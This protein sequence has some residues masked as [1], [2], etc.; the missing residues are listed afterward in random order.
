MQPKS[1]VWLDK[2]R[3]IWS[4]ILPV[5]VRHFHTYHYTVS[6]DVMVCLL[7]YVFTWSWTLSEPVW[8]KTWLNVPRNSKRGRRNPIKALGPHPDHRDN[9]RAFN[10]SLVDIQ[11]CMV[12]KFWWQYSTPNNLTLLITSRQ[13]AF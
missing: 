1:W 11:S 6:P 4:K 13:M 3:F 9:E 5:T 7:Y 12:K 10:Y 8:W 2:I